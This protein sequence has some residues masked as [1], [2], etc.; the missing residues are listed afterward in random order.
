MYPIRSWISYL[1]IP[2]MCT[3]THHDSLSLSFLLLVNKPQSLSGAVEWSLVFDVGT[4]PN[5]TA[6]RFAILI[7]NPPG[8]LHGQEH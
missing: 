7:P 4:N 8:Q 6:R 1:C 3:Y 5:V 2:V